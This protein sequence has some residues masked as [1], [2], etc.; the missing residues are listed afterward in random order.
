MNTVR[1]QLVSFA[2]GS[3]TPVEA[4]SRALAAIT[5][6]NPVYNALPTLVRANDALA[7]AE[8]L[9][10]AMHAGEAVG[11]LAGLPYVAKDTHRT[12][13]LRTTFGSPIFA[14]HVPTFNDPIVERLLDADTVLLGKSN[15]PEFAAG[16]QTFNTLFGVTRNP[17]ALDRTPGGSSGGA[18]VA[19]ASGMT[20]IADGSDLAASLRNPA[21][22]CGVV[23]LRPSSVADPALKMSANAFNTLSMVGPMGRTVD[24]VRLTWRTIFR[25]SPRR[26]IGQWSVELGEETAARHRGSLARGNAP[27]R[28]RD[29]RSLKVA[30]SID[31]NGRMPVAIPVHRAMRRA[32]H[33]LGDAGVTMVEASPDFAGADECFHTLRGLYFVENY[34]DLYATDRHRLKDTVA[35]NIEFGIDLSAERIAAAGR[36]RSEVF[37]RTARF[38]SDI[39]AWLLPTAQVLPFPHRVP[40]PTDINGETLGTYI[41]WLKSCYWVT[42]SGHPAISIPCGYES[43]GNGPRLP[44]GLQLVGRWGQD[45]ALLDIAETLETLMEPLNAARPDLAV[46]APAG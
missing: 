7:A 45:E 11:Q 42:V 15:T 12:A 43:E 10:A 23:G 40:Y 27:P 24:D 39:D 30:W 5:E 33:L 4:V 37:A 32:I 31:A 9:T 41:D 18:A 38:L 3:S 34:G 21:S 8:R 28:P 16:S 1:Q 44:V 26:T 35:W 46:G 25:P 36:V 6:H 17:Y 29:P 13:G 14:E 2:Q 19:L 20:M 22:F